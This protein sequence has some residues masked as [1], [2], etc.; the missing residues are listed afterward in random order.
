E[1]KKPEKKEEG[2]KPDNKN[3]TAVNEEEVRKLSKEG[4]AAK[5]KEVIEN[6]KNS[7]LVKLMAASA[8]VR[9]KDEYGISIT[10]KEIESKFSRAPK[11]FLKD[12]P[13]YEEGKKLKDTER[14]NLILQSK[15]A[16]IESYTDVVA[17]FRMI[18]ELEDRR[19]KSLEE[20]DK[21]DK[22]IE[23]R[24]RGGRGGKQQAVHKGRQ[25]QEEI[26]KEAD[27]NL[28]CMKRIIAH[29]MKAAKSK[30]KDLAVLAK[31]V[32]KRADEI[33]DS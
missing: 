27:L 5:L 4:D 3:S 30:D 22:K 14:I 11:D 32:L 33:L 10:E 8:L 29:L 25:Q 28:S 23:Q 21:L 9:L 7:Y 17:G 1:E 2:K 13:F 18:I 16:K 24:K 12:S 15:S 20:F 31:A 26:K 6:Q 19:R